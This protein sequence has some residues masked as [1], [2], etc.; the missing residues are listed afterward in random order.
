MAHQSSTHS[1]TILTT[2]STSQ[3]KPRPS[4][5]NT[6]HD[7]TNYPIEISIAAMDFHITKIKS[8][9][10]IKYTPNETIYQRRN[11][12]IRQH[13]AENLNGDEYVRL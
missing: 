11:C 2:S 12:R 6:A 3:K 13:L 10:T 7:V 9:L 4:Y 8:K 1:A 5:S